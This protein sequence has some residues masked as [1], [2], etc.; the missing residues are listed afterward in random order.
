MNIRS[1][2]KSPVFLILRLFALY[3]KGRSQKISLQ[4]GIR[5]LGAKFGNFAQLNMYRK[6]D[7]LNNKYFLILLLSKLISNKQYH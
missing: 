7:I 2:P 4:L 6:K 3:P 5:L 1:S